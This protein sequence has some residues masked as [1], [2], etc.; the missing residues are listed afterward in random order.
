ME[1]A[2]RQVTLRDIAARAGVSIFTVSRALNGL[3]GVSS[4]TALKIQ[5]LA[6]EMGYVPNLIGKAINR[7]K[8]KL[9][10]ALVP[11]SSPPLFTGII[12]GITTAAQRH[13]YRVFVGY[14]TDQATIELQMLTL[15]QQLHVAGIIAAL[16]P[17]TKGTS[18][19]HAM[20]EAHTPVVQIERAIDK[21]ESP[22]VLSN[23][24]EIT[25]QCTEQLIAMGRRKIAYASTS[26]H[27]TASRERIEGYRQAMAGAGIP[28]APGWIRQFRMARYNEFM[29][30]AEPFFKQAGGLDA[31]F[32]DVS[33][34]C[35]ISHVLHDLGWTNGREI[36]I[37]TFDHYPDRDLGGEEFLSID[38]D[39][40]EMGKAAF[41]LFL[42]TQRPSE[43]I[44]GSQTETA[45]NRILRVPS[46]LVLNSG[47]KATHE[48]HP[49]S[50]MTSRAKSA[51]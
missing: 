14:S 8:T 7:K 40:E 12:S 32:W 48:V 17:E 36:E 10:G 16:L 38:Q 19:L 47:T 22:A 25:R 44:S 24:K 27:T 43:I 39:G 1:K 9:I 28:I 37:I 42:E 46:L 15:F 3:S 30:Q 50:F 11:V 13:D 6:E 20:K 21:L 34:C 35:T 2:Y 23:N 49:T 26:L 29:Q 31:V 18:L 51:V 41:N 45:A 33:F 5:T 4:E